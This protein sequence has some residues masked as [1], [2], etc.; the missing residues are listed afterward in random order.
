[1]H[2]AL[3]RAKRGLWCPDSAAL[4]VEVAKAVEVTAGANVNVSLFEAVAAK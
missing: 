3:P 2:A 1:M 4:A